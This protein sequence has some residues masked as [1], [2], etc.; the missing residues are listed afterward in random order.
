MQLPELLPI[1]FKS[2]REDSNGTH[3]LP[4]STWQI[5]RTAIMGIFIEASK[6]K[7]NISLCG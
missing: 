5:L 4:Q 6:S 7:K 1:A 3:A 2:K